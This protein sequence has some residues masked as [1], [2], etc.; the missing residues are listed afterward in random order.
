MNRHFIRPQFIQLTS[1]VAVKQIHWNLFTGNIQG[2]LYSH[3][4]LKCPVQQVFNSYYEVIA[5]TRAVSKQMLPTNRL[6]TSSLWL[7]RQRGLSCSSENGSLVLLREWNSWN[8]GL[9]HVT[10]LTPQLSPI[11]SLSSLSVLVSFLPRSIGHAW[12]DLGPCK[13]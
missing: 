1:L 6:I 9:T 11:I 13:T 3:I 2:Q 7:S 5:S 12:V 8:N 10:P 4:T